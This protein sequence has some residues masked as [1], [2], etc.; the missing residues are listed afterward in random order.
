MTILHR[1]FALSIRYLLRSLAL[2]LS[3]YVGIAQVFRNFKVQRLFT[4]ILPFRGDIIEDQAFARNNRILTTVKSSQRLQH[5]R[6]RALAHPLS[7]FLSNRE[8]LSYPSNDP[9]C[10]IFPYNVPLKCC[11]Y[12]ERYG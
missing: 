1:P 5:R 9:L 12:G 10:N 2:F 3:R 6:L 7:V 11:P 4:K 8:I